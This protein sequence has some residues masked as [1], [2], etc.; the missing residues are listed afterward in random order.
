MVTPSDNLEIVD[1]A[2]GGG[3]SQPNYTILYIC[4]FAGS[5]EANLSG[6]LAD[7]LVGVSP[8]TLDEIQATSMPAASFGVADPTSSQ[9]ALTSVDLSF[10]RLADFRPLDLAK[11]FP[12]TKQ[13]LDLRDLLV[14]RLEGR[15]DDGA[16]HSALAS[17]MEHDADLTWITDT[18]KWTGSSA[19]AP[20]DLVD[21]VLGG[22]DFG[23]ESTPSS[24]VKD[25]VSEL[26]RGDNSLSAEQASGIRR[27]LAELDRRI[28]LWLTT[29]LHSKEIRNLER[30]WRSL[31]F[32]VKQ[33]DFREGVR[34]Q[35]L[36]ASRDDLAERLV[37]HVVNP[38]FDDGQA[39]PDLIILGDTFSNSASDMERLDELAQH[40]ASIPTHIVAGC[41]SS[42]FGVKHAWQVA[43]L[44]PIRSMFDQF[45]FAKWRSLRGQPYAR[46]MAAVCG[47]GL[48][49]EPHTI[50]S[51]A[52]GFSYRE[53]RI[54]ER[55]F[56]WCSGALAVAATF[57]KSVARCGWPTALAGQ[58]HGQVDGLAT[59]VGGKKGNK[60]FGPTDTKLPE[61]RI[62][63]F[64][65]VGMAAL[66]GREDG[67]S[68]LCNGL[69][70][71][72]PGKV[73]P[74][75]ILEVSLGYQLFAARLGRLMFDLKPSLAG[76]SAEDVIQ[77]VKS[78]LITWVGYKEEPTAE[79]LTVDVAP[80]PENPQVQHLAVKVLAPEYILPGGIPVVLGYPL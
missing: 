24:P 38:V 39:A 43:T 22:I 49:R 78:H 58:V 74:E 12:K 10:E 54:A 65:A 76:R 29:L 71:A 18:L 16:F 66:L 35:V 60:P 26:A 64:A 23:E 14:S 52:D 51:G 27:T 2:A 73:S 70:P 79:H 13:L 61:N 41:A 33:L 80:H 4:D 72:H 63:E 11:R 50:E 28:G 47:Q 68:I 17:Q 8:G 62:D 75:A 56:L 15:L 25:V 19:A 30:A 44:P 67:T 9:N 3:V 37:A 32:L 20:S 46:F 5:N 36:H 77:R 59:A 34:L 31:A 40:A 48:L 69:T 53:P 57:S 42:F 55:D 1:D 21:S 45:Q 6:D 7:G